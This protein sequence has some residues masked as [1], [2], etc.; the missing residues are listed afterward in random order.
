M[1]SIQKQ[2][3]KQ[4]KETKTKQKPTYKQGKAN[5]QTP[6]YHRTEHTGNIWFYWLETQMAALSKAEAQGMDRNPEQI[7]WVPEDGGAVWM[8]A[9]CSR[10]HYRAPN[11]PVSLLPS[12]LKAGDLNTT[13][14]FSQK[15]VRGK[16]VCVC[17][18]ACVRVCV[19]VC[20][21]ACVCRYFLT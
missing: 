8:E 14:K 5:T 11:T 17:V 16:Q 21:H 15:Y 1:L 2:T 3:N 10:L 9:L 18:H 4:K 7:Q 6:Q 19:H 12:T 13:W 20:V